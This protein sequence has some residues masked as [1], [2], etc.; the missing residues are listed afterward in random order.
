MA[1]HEE[2]IEELIQIMSTKRNGSFL[3]T[4]PKEN[5]F[6]I[7]HMYRMVAKQFD[8]VII[9][10]Y[11][12]IVYNYRPDESITHSITIPDVASEHPASCDEGGVEAI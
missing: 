12:P 10:N 2:P 1:F 8:E 7:S 3:L 9:I 11:M 5:K 6:C 4:K